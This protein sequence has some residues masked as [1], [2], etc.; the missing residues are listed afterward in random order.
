M[1]IEVESLRKT[2]G[3]TIAVE[4]ASFTVKKGEIFGLLGPNGAGKTTIVECLQGLRQPDSGNVSVLGF[5]P[6]SQ[7]RI[8]RR[9]IG[10]QLQQ[11]A[12]PDRIKVWETLDLFASL[13]P[14]SVDWR[15]LMKQWGLSDKYKASFASLSGGQKQRLFV[16]L[17]LVND[18]KVVFLDEMTTGLD[19][20]AR[21]VAWDLIHAMRDRGATVILVTHFMDEAEKLCDRLIIIN[22]GRIIDSD[23][24]QGLITK[25]ADEIR[26]IFTAESIDLTLLEKLSNVNRVIRKGPRTEV[27]GTGPLLALTA[28]TL[29]EHGIIPN[30]LRVEQPT[31]E[32][33][34]LKL[35][36]QSI[37]E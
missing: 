26:V 9:Y 37:R 16:A 35:T 12:L 6:R 27:E 25:H 14:K 19:P 20:A 4:D 3:A 24:P 17:A 23:T 30:D 28:A 5:D 33:V 29:V 32:D 2:Y 21:H 10:S 8:L 34:F 31:L 11:S 1:I 15:L 22:E 13:T 36:G 7:A 18:P